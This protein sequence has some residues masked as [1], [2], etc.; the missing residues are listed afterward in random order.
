MKIIIWILRLIVFV[1]L[2]VLAARNSQTVTIEFFF[3]HS[4]QLPLNL[5]MLIFFAAGSAVGITAAL[6]TNFRQRRDISRLRREGRD[7][8]ELL[9]KSKEAEKK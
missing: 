6:G 7:A 4:W 2:L 8:D 5:V 3:D 1:L 9:A